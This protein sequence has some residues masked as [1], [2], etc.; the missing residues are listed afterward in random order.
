MRTENEIKDRIRLTLIENMNRRDF[1]NILEEPENAL[2][3]FI[4]DLTIH[5]HELVIDEITNRRRY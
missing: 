3:Q 4:E 1:R 5:L 2:P